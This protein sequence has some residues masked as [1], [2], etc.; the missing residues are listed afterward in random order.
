MSKNEL[1]EFIAE[2]AGLTKADSQRA[3]D[4]TLKGIEKGLIEEGKV[5]LVGFGVFSNK[6][7]AERNGVNPLNKEPIVIPAKN[8][9][10]FKAGSKLKAAVNE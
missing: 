9:V 7:R 8:V 6:T 4:A 2:T 3:L 1:V 10:S 5:T